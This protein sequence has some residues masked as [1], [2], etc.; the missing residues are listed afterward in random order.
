[1]ASWRKRIIAAGVVSFGLTRAAAAAPEEPTFYA[2]RVGPIFEEH[3]AACH[4]AEKHKGGLRLDGYDALMRGGDDG[5]VIKPGDPAGSELY[6]RIT[7]SPR[8]EDFMP[9]EGEPPLMPEDVRVLELWIASGASP[10]LPLG[11]IADAPDPKPRAAPIQPLAPDYRPRLGEL[12]GLEKLT[13]VRLVP[14]SQVPTDG[15]VLRTASRP[16]ECNDAVLEQLAPIAELIVDAE[17]ARTAIT[18]AG[19]KTLARFPNLRRLDLSRTA[20]TAAGVNALRPLAKLEALNLTDTRV[21][22]TAAAELRVLPALTKVWRFGTGAAAAASGS[23]A[24]RK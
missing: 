15:L 18:D 3:C 9:G 4:A 5:A 21:D 10:V 1:M 7:L 20:I 22:E 23:T 2:A 13:G 16:G 11:A 24:D 6:R 14:R 12:A 19:L 17:L 8:D